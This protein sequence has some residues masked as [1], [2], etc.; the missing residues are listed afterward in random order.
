[1]ASDA[2]EAL[3]SR[4]AGLFGARDLLLGVGLRA[5]L[6]GMNIGFFIII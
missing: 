5:L 1:M 4:V 6:S 2:S 3:D